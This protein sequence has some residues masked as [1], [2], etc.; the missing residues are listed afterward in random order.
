MKFIRYLTTGLVCFATNAFAGGSNDH[1]HGEY[2]IG[3]PGTK[4]V[5]R[6]VNVRMYEE[7]GKMLYRPGTLKFKKGQTVKIRLSN[8][9]E[10]EHEFVMDTPQKNVEHKTLMEKFPEMEHDD[11]NALRLKPKG[12]GAIF[13][14]FTKRGEFEYACLIRGHYE[15]G[16]RGKILVE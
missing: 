1:S 4:K 5:S 9:G 10:L 15:A 7:D 8:Q 16:M 3:E 2:A 14:K 12:S 13:W 6:V 11:P